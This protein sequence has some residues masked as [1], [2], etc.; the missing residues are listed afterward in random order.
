MTKE[1]FD[2]KTI[3]VDKKQEPVRIDSYLSYR[4]SN[5]S[6]TKI[7]KAIK[8]GNVF[9]NK[10]NVKGSY[11][12][13]PNDNIE[14]KISKPKTEFKIERENIPLNIIY[15]DDSLLVVNK[16][17]G[18]VVHPS[19]GH[20]SGTLVNALI[21]H[22]KNFKLLEKDNERPGLIHRIDKNTSGLLVIAKTEYAKNFLS[23]QF[24]NH[25]TKRR[26]YAL[27]WGDFKEDKGTI[28]GHIGRHPKNR[29]I[30]HVFPN[31]EHGKDAVTHF[32]V[33]ERFTYVSLLE[34]YLETGR[35]HQIRVHFKH[36]KHP[37]FN[38][39][40]YGGDKILRGT[41]FSKY[42]QFINNCFKILP[43]QALHAKSLGFIHPKSKKELYFDS[44]LPED[45]N[46]I[47]KK[48]RTYISNRKF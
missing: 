48:W 10:K 6:R 21:Y 47:L 31:A 29:K 25:T 12:V 33:I 34:C 39:P 19:Y 46:K 11:K 17:A 43:R 27:V 41:T 30:M 18:M 40:E 16:P 7:E 36:I 3:K 24:F 5:I 2:Y 1:L 45:M 28:K 20:Y 26:Y 9:V 8:A 44:E 23:E 35:T 4:L 42:K 15:E 38:D 13:R 14:I 37:L 32:K 22:I